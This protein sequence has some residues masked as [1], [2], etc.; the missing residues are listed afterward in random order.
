M[1][2]FPAAQG[3]AFLSATEA[4]L[5]K[6]LFGDLRPLQMAAAPLPFVWPIFTTLWLGLRLAG[7]L[8][9]PPWEFWATVVW[10]M[11]L[12]ACGMLLVFSAINVA[13]LSLT[14]PYLAFTPALVVGTGYLML[15]ETVR[16]AGLA[17][18]LAIVAGSYVLNLGHF[19]RDDLLAPLRA[20]ARE[21]GSR[22]MLCAACLYA[23]TSVLGKKLVLL[24]GP[25]QSALAFWSLSIPVVLLVLT[26]SGR[27]R[28]GLLLARPR[29]G[30]AVALVM[31][32]HLLL[33]MYA[34]GLTKVAHMIAV[35]RLAGFFSV[36]YGGLL[37]RERNLAPLLAG[38]L[39][40]A[41]GAGILAA[42]G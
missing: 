42:W 6:K 36:I 4:A 22:M 26:L 14:M 3:V 29:S 25:L 39:L 18:I 28:P 27:I 33:H 2:W 9:P 20:I 31:C 1:P 16:P 34:V 38:S 11:P 12:D 17:G 41:A 37:F 10:L 15:G 8:Q 13:P 40:M 7:V 30:L 24:A 21:P 35:K 5:L 32:C 23:V 19:R